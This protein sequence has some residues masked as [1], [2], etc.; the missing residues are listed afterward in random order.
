L[1][2]EAGSDAQQ[3]DAVSSTPAL[4]TFASNKIWYDCNGSM[5]SRSQTLAGATTRTSYGWDEHNRLAA[6]ATGTPVTWT[7]LSDAS[8]D[9]NTNDLISSS[10]LDGTAYAGSATSSQALT[11]DGAVSFRIRHNRQ[12]VGLDTT[13]TGTGYSNIDY[14]IDRTIN[15]TVAV[16]ENGILRCPIVSECDWFEKVYDTDIFSIQRQGSTITYLRNGIVFY[17]STVA[18]SGSYYIDTTAANPNTRIGDVSIS[19]GNSGVQ[20]D[21]Y[22]A[23][24]LR[25][26]RVEP[27]GTKT[28]YLGG[29]E[30]RWSPTTPTTINVAR[31]YPGGTER[32]FDGQLRHAL[33]GYQNS[34]LASVNATTGTITHNRYLPYG[35]MRSGSTPSDKGFLNQT[36]D[37]ATSLTYLNNRYHDP[38]LGMFISVDPLV[39]A[40]GEPYIY[41]SAKPTTLSD[42][43]GLEPGC[44]ATASTRQVAICAAS[45]ADAKYLANTSSARQLTGQTWWESRT[46]DEQLPSWSMTL[47]DPPRPPISVCGRRPDLCDA[48]PGQSGLGVDE[49]LQLIHE[50]EGL[51]PDEFYELALDPDEIDERGLDFLN[52]GNDGCSNVPDSIGSSLLG[53]C[54]RHDFGYRNLKAWEGHTGDDLFNADSQRVVDNLLQD[55]IYEV[56]GWECD[57]AAPVYWSGVNAWGDGTLKPWRGWVP[58]L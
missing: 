39:T 46:P 15:G 58:G 5:I 7:N 24:G 8:V 53:P 2:C 51:S 29:T 32:D 43:T 34:L 38:Q 22:D 28:I 57:W 42:P 36:H 20:R 25:V 21:V 33:N 31:Y 41:A 9:P 14:A 19:T 44:S 3:P 48:N 55:G 35:T 47:P 26:L 10:T 40:T 11:G 23:T 27:N 49:E 54:A 1:A 4:G 16:Y 50:L 30:L 37:T 45:H 17:T 52:W 18:A 56:C 6:V 12:F 13:G